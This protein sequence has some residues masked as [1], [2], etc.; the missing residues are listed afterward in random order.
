MVVAVEAVIHLDEV[1]VGIGTSAEV[2]G[3]E[4][5]ETMTGEV[6]AEETGM[7]AESTIVVV[8]V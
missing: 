1:E 5:S 4:D 6:A 2:D 3:T 8:V 7:A